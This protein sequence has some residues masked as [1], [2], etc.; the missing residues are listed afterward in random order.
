MAKVSTKLIERS[1]DLAYRERRTAIVRAWREWYHS[2]IVAMSQQVR[3][4]SL[5]PDML[6]S[7][8]LGALQRELDHCEEVGHALFGFMRGDDGEDGHDR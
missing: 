6:V 8:E 5:E 3:R 4:E 1:G 2:I 7:N